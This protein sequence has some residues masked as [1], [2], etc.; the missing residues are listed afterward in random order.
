[1]DRQSAR[2]LAVTVNGFTVVITDYKPKTSKKIELD[3]EKVPEEEKEH[4]VA[5]SPGHVN[6]NNKNN[7]N[8]NNH[9]DS[10]PPP[11]LE[12]ELDFQV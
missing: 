5:V 9:H 6:D 8:I 10:S 4:S 11:K 2:T 1:M 3:E 7:N 12:N